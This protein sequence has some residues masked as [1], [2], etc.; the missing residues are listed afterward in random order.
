MYSVELAT[1]SDFDGW[2]DAARRLASHRI[3]ASNVCWRAGGE[4]EDLFAAANDLPE[5][6]GPHPVR[7]SKRFLD[8]AERAVCRGDPS[9]FARLYKLLMRLQDKPR[10]L[11][12]A[13]DGDVAWLMGLEKSVRRDIHK[14]HAFVRFRKTGERDGRET[15]VAW[16]EPEHRIVRLA[17]T[18]FRNRF[19]NMDWTIL[20][21]HEFVRWDGVRL[22][23]G[24]GARREDAP[25][26]DALEEHW[27]TYFRSIFNPAR[28]KI[29]A[30][31]SEMPRKYWKNLPEASLIRE[32]IAEAPRRA[33]EMA[34]NA[35]SE[36]APLAA[37]IAERRAAMPDGDPQTLAEARQFVQACRRC[38]LCDH[39]SQAVFGEGPDNA[40]LMI[41]G[42]QPGDQEDLAGRPFV[43]PAGEVL[44]AGLEAAGLDRSQAWITNAVKHFKFKRRGKRRLHQTPDTSEIDQC[45]WWLDFERAQ[46]K[47]ELIVALGATACRS[48]L[49]P[50][51]RLAD[52]RGKIVKPRGTPVLVTYH[53]AYLLREPDADTN[54]QAKAAFANDLCRAREFLAARL[55]GRRVGAML[56]WRRR[57]MPCPCP[58]PPPLSPVPRPVSVMPRPKC[59]SRRAGMSSPVSGRMRMPRSSARR[60]ATMSRRCRW[61]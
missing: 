20:T 15:F 18:F 7:A 32:M 5:T 11:G 6:D 40:R 54:A 41:V 56:L 45:R 13:A 3:P 25:A 51:V 27:K 60:S 57:N 39:A 33:R 52:V 28:V 37:K 19:A 30:M 8:F 34:L 1:P 4:G 2:R 10:L 21:P 31:T 61:K 46:V 26:D 38:G 16:F 59:S 35:I 24:S 36:P 50:R 23:F 47:P 22:E 29:S 14:M 48:L 44:D 9:R 49:G 42:E 53:P 17:S 43:G 12:D 58:N 55:A